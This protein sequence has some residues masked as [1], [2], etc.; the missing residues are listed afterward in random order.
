MSDDNT[1]KPSLSIQHCRLK[2][3][4]HEHEDRSEWLEHIFGE[5]FAIDL[6]N[7]TFL[8]LHKKLLTE[9]NCLHLVGHVLEVDCN[10]RLAMKLDALDAD[11]VKLLYCN[12]RKGGLI[13]A[14]SVDFLFQRV[15]TIPLL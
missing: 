1:N 10:G 11:L 8:F 6:A 4:L 13:S 7:I 15:N 14:F 12:P 3:L 2:H 9:L 5:H